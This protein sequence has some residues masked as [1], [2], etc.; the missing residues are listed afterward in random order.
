MINH[1]NNT[2]DKLTKLC[3]N[4][5]HV[6]AK[7]EVGHVR[8][9]L[10]VQDIVRYLDRSLHLHRD[11]LGIYLGVDREKS[12]VFYQGSAYEYP[13]SAQATS[14]LRKGNDLLLK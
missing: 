5:K 7:M 6:L 9:S 12:Q 8:N 10:V 4:V 11:R 13:T 1:I 2:A 3:S 14:G